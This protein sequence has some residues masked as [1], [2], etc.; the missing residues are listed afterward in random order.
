MV[1]SS[2]CPPSCRMG[3]AK[4]P[5][6]SLPF[7]RDEYTFLRT[8]KTAH[9][10]SCIQCSPLYWNLKEDTQEQLR[11]SD[12]TMSLEG[13]WRANVVKWRCI[14]GVMLNDPALGFMQAT[15]CTFVTSLNTTLP[16]K[17]H[18]L[19][20]SHHQHSDFPKSRTRQVIAG[21]FIAFMLTACTSLK[22]TGQTRHHYYALKRSEKLVSVSWE[23]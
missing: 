8:S 23:G 12:L 10:G 21:S 5:D 13:I 20:D 17:K 11:M 3:G 19:S 18:H 15:Y 22:M 6:S 16:C 1:A 4:P 14:L 7:R 2:S 9:K